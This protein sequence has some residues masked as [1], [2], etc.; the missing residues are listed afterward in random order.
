VRD[1]RA[2]A[3][4]LGALLA[5]ERGGLPP[6]GFDLGNSPRELRPEV[7]GGRRIVLTTTNG[8]A[9]VARCTGAERVLAGALVN[10]EATGR[11]LADASPARVWLVCAGSGGELAL[12]DVAAAGCLAG[13]LVLSAGAELGPGARLAAAYFDQWKHDLH[14]VLAESTS[15]RKLIDVGLGDDLVHC[16]RVDALPFAVVL[17]SAGRFVK[18][19][20]R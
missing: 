9:A 8:T 1:A 14:A 15:G 4:E 17:D 20:A 18:S 19:G 2:R 5:G 13:Q 6:E 7:V 3:A 12:D 10:A 16:A 11:A